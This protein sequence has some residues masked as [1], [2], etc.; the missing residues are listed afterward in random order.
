MPA[1]DSF[2]FATAGRI[3][4]G[5]GAVARVGSLAAE[6]GKRALVV[7]GRGP[8]RA[9][10]AVEALAAS[11]IS[12]ELFHVSGEPT[13]EDAQNG[14]ARARALGAELVV[15]VG[16]GSAIDA[17]KAI[18]ALL[19]NG[20][21]ALDYLEVIGGGRKLG[22][23]SVPYIA[24][25][26]TAG[27]GA[28]VTRNAVL[29]SPE[30]RVKVSLRS[31]YMLPAVAL[32]D[33]ELTLSVPP[34][35]TASTGFDA[36]SQ[37]LEPYVSNQANPLTDAICREGMTRAA[38]S[39]RRA[40]EHGSDLAARA[41]MAVTSLCGGLALANAKLG[42]VHGFAGPLGG[43]FNA[44]H[45][46]ICA[47]LLPHVVDVNVRALRSRSGSGERLARFD[48]VA[49]ILTG[50]AS[51]SADDAVRWLQDLA[52]SLDIPGL[53]SYGVHDV[54]FE[55]IA[56]KARVSSSM[57]GNP[58]TLDRDDLFEILRKAL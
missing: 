46:A 8:E 16:G 23:P 27:T 12:C 24:V 53:G 57:Q 9:A 41:D 31:A 35:V 45:G 36:L 39:L 34:A 19:A 43:M 56:N 20:G 55:S 1:G 30:H 51:A 48:D 38:R 14:V 5:C 18:A 22:R 42:A 25:P 37:V 4:F 13:T 15:G 33:P 21:A 49:R 2:E 17:G 32:I 54:E 11:G 26:T 10:R 58:I 47:A 44:P 52:R 6:F 7:T 3:V 28:E 50:S 40:F 29:D